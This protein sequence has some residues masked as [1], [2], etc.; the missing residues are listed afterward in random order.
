M[1][2]LKDKFVSIFNENP[3]YLF[4][5]PSRI[6]LIGEHIDYNGGNVL[7]AAISKYIYACVSVRNDDLICISSTEIE[8]LIKC[9]LN[10]ISYKK[11]NDWGNY[12]FG[13]F[14]ILMDQGYK[15]DKG[16]NILVSSEIPV[17]SGLSSSAALLDLI[18]Y[19][20]NDSGI[21]V[22]YRYD[23]YGELLQIIDDSQ[24]NIGE[25]NHIIYKSYYYDFESG[26]YYLKS[27]YYNPSIGIFIQPDKADYLQFDD[28]KGYGLYTYCFNNPVLYSDPEGNFGI[29]AGIIIG[30][31]ISGAVI[32]GAIS[33]I[34]GAVSGDRGLTLFFDV[35]GGAAVGA[36]L[37]L[38]TAIGGAVAAGMI[39]GGLAVGA[40]LGTTA[41]SF[42]AGSF[43]SALNQKLHNGKI[44]LRDTLV[45]G[46][47]TAAQS[48]VAFGMGA[49][50]RY[51][52][53]WNS[54]GQKELIGSIKMGC[55]FSPTP[56]GFVRGI[57]MYIE[58]NAFQIMC[59]TF[60]KNVFTL[61]Y[62]L[63]KYLI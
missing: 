43:Q 24:N 54:L 59:R 16:L 31:V 55:T 37:S 35:L 9:S 33:G 14:K 56:A 48:V 17:G 38:A 4:K 19:I 52:G 21:I 47:L 11:E 45:A 39:T 30:A 32:G 49:A 41:L 50:M 46:G 22:T 13:M 34:S 44:S 5:A 51:C 10:D 62:A 12:V 61:P 6:N 8:G 20:L 29:I 18:C 25:I 7:P 42:A 60:V 26:L 57:A 28:I 40:F 23:A 2:N 1:K 3:K 36:C 53:L 27:R 15:I 63:F 58:R